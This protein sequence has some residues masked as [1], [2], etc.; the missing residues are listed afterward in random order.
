MNDLD[1]FNQ[2]Q[3]DAR[4]RLDSFARSIFLIAG[5]TLTITI[6]VFIDTESI[7]IS[8]DN[9]GQLK[10]AWELLIFSILLIMVT[11]FGLLT[12]QYEFGKR[13]A[14][15][16]DGGPTAKHSKFTEVL[17]MSTYLLGVI[18]FFAGMLFMS[19]FAINHVT[20]SLV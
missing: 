16:L 9:A 13:W 1:R 4:N 10:L 2:H 19:I 6:S 7:K 18:S 20:A 15:Q 3:E 17:I 8:V 11:L 14:K 5:G 12:D